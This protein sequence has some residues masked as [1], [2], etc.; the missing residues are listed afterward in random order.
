MSFSFLT[1]IFGK[2]DQGNNSH[3][4]TE[5]FQ[6]RSPKEMVAIVLTESQ[7]EELSKAFPEIIATAIKV[8]I[9]NLAVEKANDYWGNRDDLSFT[10]KRGIW[11]LSF[12]CAAAINIRLLE[13][14]IPAQLEQYGL[15]YPMMLLVSGSLVT[16]IDQIIDSELSA[17]LLF[18]EA[19]RVQ[20]SLKNSFPGLFTLGYHQGRTQAFNR[21]Q[22]QYLAKPSWFRK[23]K[24]GLLPVIALAEY[25]AAISNALSSNELERF[26]ILAF[27]SPLVGVMLTGMSGLFKA[28]VI[29]YPHHKQRVADHYYHLAM[30]TD[31]HGALEERVKYA[32][33]VASEFVRDPD[34]SREHIEQAQQED[35]Y[36]TLQ[37]ELYEETRERQR[38]YQEGLIELNETLNS[39]VE[40]IEAKEA[41]YLHR[42]QKLHEFQLRKNHLSRSHCRARLNLAEG[43]LS[44]LVILKSGYSC[45][46]VAY[47]QFK[48]E[49]EQHQQDFQN[50]LRMLLKEHQA[51]NSMTLPNSNIVPFVRE[52]DDDDDLNV[53]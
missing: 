23:C 40:E 13:A 29:D 28:S 3:K 31:A 49:L 17:F 32:N 53:A 24:L 27:C 45:E 22:A 4:S 33:T 50:R 26:G 18:Q 7:Q 5:S 14:A 9:F 20:K 35:I 19:E 2:S 43:M 36:Q 1:N 37:N 21:T 38:V 42:P 25:G 48:A 16:L 34:F 51:L 10:A 30:E 6:R 46:L 52:E 39:K 41:E 47:D 44:D 11:F 8:G 15:S 12:A